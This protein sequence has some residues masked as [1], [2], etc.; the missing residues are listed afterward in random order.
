MNTENNM[1][2]HDVFKTGDRVIYDGPVRSFAGSIGIVAEVDARGWVE[3]GFRNGEVLLRVA[4]ASIHHA[5]RPRLAG[6]RIDNLT[7]G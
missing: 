1:G 6:Q 3:V 7:P 2:W 4:Q 5:D